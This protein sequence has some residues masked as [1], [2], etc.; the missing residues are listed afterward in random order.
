MLRRNR[1]AML[2][3]ALPVLALTAVHVIV[4]SGEPRYH[5]Q[6]WPA[7]LVGSAALADAALRRLQRPAADPR[8]EVLRGADA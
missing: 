4:G 3:L 8:E 5:F 2:V 1:E 7:L 6:A